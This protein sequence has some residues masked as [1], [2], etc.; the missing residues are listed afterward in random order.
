MITVFH[1]H[2]TVYAARPIRPHVSK[3]IKKVA[4]GLAVIFLSWV[5]SSIVNLNQQVAVLRFRAFGI[6]SANR[7]ANPVDPARTPLLAFPRLPE[8][9]WLSKELPGEK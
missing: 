8:W 1:P 3:E 7:Q 2:L 5:A 6:A 4:A 9:L